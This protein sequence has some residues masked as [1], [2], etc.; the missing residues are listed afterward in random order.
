MLDPLSPIFAA[1]SGT[2]A[3][4]TPRAEDP[5][6]VQGLEI[7]GV[8]LILVTASWALGG[9]CAAAWVWV[10]SLRDRDAYQ[11]ARRPGRPSRR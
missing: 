6:A 3:Q 7:F 8:I 9:V 2:V 10:S 1:S 4:V 11:P 5:G